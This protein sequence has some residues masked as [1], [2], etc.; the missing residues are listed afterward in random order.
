LR[1]LVLF[2]LLVLAAVIRA[3]AAE[4]AQ[5]GPLIVLPRAATPPPRPDPTPVLR[6]LPAMRPL[7]PLPSLAPATPQPY[8]PPAR[9]DGKRV[10]AL[11]I[12]HTVAAPGAYSARGRGEFYFNQEIVRLIYA[13]LEKSPRVA[14]FI[15][16]PDGA[17]ISLPMRAALA[18]RHG[19]ELF[20][21]IHHDAVVDSY[22]VPW[23][24]EG[25]RQRYCDR[26]LGYG[27]FVSPKNPQA[28]ASL[29]FGQL[30]GGAMKRAGFPFSPHHSEM[31]KGESRRILDETNGVYE[32]S[33]LIVLK[34]ALMPAALLECGV[35]VHRDQELLLR[36]RATQQKI[37]HAAILAIEEFLRPASAAAR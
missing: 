16:N 26:F 36:E 29:H 37:A 31:V 27:V 7:A 4:P 19:A 5:E 34:T 13:Q 21:A 8:L 10:V 32:Y 22:L 3:P 17:P 24:V 14:P 12:G 23:E 28:A 20:L 11:D 18:A 9:P 6:P 2:F 33:D 30:L 35:I 25:K 15:V 1:T